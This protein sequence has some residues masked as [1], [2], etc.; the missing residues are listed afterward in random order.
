MIGDGKVTFSWITSKGAVIT[1][2]S[3][4]LR[5]EQIR[6]MVLT[7]H[8]RFHEAGPGSRESEESRAERKYI[9][10][11]PEETLREAWNL[12]DKEGKMEMEMMLA[13]AA[14]HGISDPQWANRHVKLRDEIIGDDKKELS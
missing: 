13:P 12:L 5:P 7:R 9:S 3:K 11:H 8:E 14:H 6:D 2:T 4:L 10:A 1:Q